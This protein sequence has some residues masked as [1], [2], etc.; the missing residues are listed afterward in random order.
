M[1]RRTRETTRGG[2]KEGRSREK[3]EKNCRERKQGGM[4][5]ERSIP[6]NSKRSHP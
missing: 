3:L 5:K 2:V 6:E 4:I 1:K